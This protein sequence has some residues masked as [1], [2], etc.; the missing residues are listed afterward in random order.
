RIECDGE[1]I[2][3]MGELHPQL[4]QK[5]DLPLAPIVFEVN[6]A[7]LQDRQLPQY[8]E[9]S[10]YQAAVRD[11]AIVVPE[12]VPVQSLL[13]VLLDAARQKEACKIVQAVV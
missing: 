5:Y 13:D 3:V 9:I 2:G 4:Q 10:K 11:L 7:A 8:Q 12:H 1:E 6:L